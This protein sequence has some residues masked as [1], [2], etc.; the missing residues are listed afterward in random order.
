MGTV[1][2]RLR[3]EIEPGV[4]LSVA[5]GRRP[6]PVVTKAGAFGTDD[7]LVR[8]R[9][10]LRAGAHPASAVAAASR[11]QSDPAGPASSGR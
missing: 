11:S 7:T 4:P 2:L 6:I 9:A 1:A 3:G 10:R 5:V 8:V